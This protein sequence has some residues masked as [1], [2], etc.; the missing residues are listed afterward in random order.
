MDDLVPNEDD[1][2]PD[3]D[4]T[5][6][7]RQAA[8]ATLQRLMAF[9]QAFENKLPQQTNLEDVNDPNLVPGALYSI[10]GSAEGTFQV[11][12]VLALDDL[13]IHICLYGNAFARRPTTIAP[14]LLD[15]APFLSLAPEDIGQEWPLS[16]GHLPLMVS[17]FLGMQPVFIT[18]TDVI[19]EELE[20]YEEWKEA[21][22]GYI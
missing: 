21:G 2:Q 18:R 3:D 9:L 13:G 22:G 19:P 5:E 4:S 1:E 8:E 16:V 17:T 20:G 11:I 6:E 10:R 7:Y 12:K 14:E 15:T